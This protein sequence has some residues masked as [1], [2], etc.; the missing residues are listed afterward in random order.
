MFHAR[1]ALLGFLILLVS[2]S[3]S[4][5]RARELVPE[6][7]VV[8]TFDDSVKS[9]Y[10]VAA[11]L[12]E[13]HGF[14]ATFFITEGFSFPANKKDYMTWEEIADLHRRGFEIG[15]HTRSHLSVT[16]GTVERLEEELRA[17]DERCDEHGIPHPVSFA[18]PGNAITP[19]ALPILRSHGI[20]WARRGGAPE[21]P[22]ET[23]RGRG[24]EPEVD[25]PLLIPTAADARPTW[26]LED[27]VRG[28]EK[29]TAGRIAV[30]Q[31]HGVPEGEHPW[32]N[33]PRELFE[34]CIEWLAANDYRAVALRDLER[35]VDPAV[36]PEHP[37]NVIG[38]RA[39]EA[40]RARAR[41]LGI[42]IGAIPTGAW[43]AITDVPGVRVGHSSIWKG[44]SVR[45]GVT[46]ILPHSGDL[47]HDRVPAAFFCFNGFGKPFGVAQIEELGEL[48]TPLLLGPT[49]SVPRIADAVID[50]VLEKDPGGTVVSVNPAVGEVNDGYLSDIRERPI[51]T[52]EVRAAV[53]GARSGPVLEGAVGA[54]TGTRTLGYKGGIG[55]SSRIVERVGAKHAVGVLVLT[56]FGGELR[57]DGESLSPDE[58][59][60][61]AAPPREPAPATDRDGSCVIVIAT[62]AAL[63]SRQLGRLAR[64][65]FAGM[66][67]TGASF[68]HGSGDYAFAFSTARGEGAKGG[69]PDAEL[70]PLFRAAA[71]ATEEAILNAL[72]QAREATG[73][74]GRTV[75][76]V[77]LERVRAIVGRRASKEEGI[78]SPDGT[79]TP[80][81]K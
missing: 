59:G 15:N 4:S 75:K 27:F 53:E 54:G 40:G 48:E 24:Y 76:P 12:L 7:V 41:D 58:E 61:Q 35:W 26:T 1:I 69:I 71:D 78:G 56:N 73:Q 10:T 46:A 43:N 29:A 21:Y 31:F 57:I 20:L 2:S 11:P 64:R 14:N 18:W 37:W 34:K 38:A 13:R 25:H 63:D 23:G 55:S 67:R 39:C 30:I 77:P 16:P 51:G 44:D 60:T 47:F 62:D 28:V 72:F 32:V 79:P 9:Q 36:L 8:L 6:R 66:A 17:I 42:A 33:T 50:L 70:S 22:Y 3:M 81:R 19:E 80:T 52:A 74:A 68:S 49:L 5:L 65:T 45:T